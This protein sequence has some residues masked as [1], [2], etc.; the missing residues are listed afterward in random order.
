MSNTFPA[1]VTPVPAQNGIGAGP[2]A[3]PDTSGDVSC[4]AYFLQGAVVVTEDVVPSVLSVSIFAVKMPLDGQPVVPMYGY[5]FLPFLIVLAGIVTLKS[6]AVA[7]APG[8]G[9]IRSGGTSKVSL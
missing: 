7:Y 5:F 9:W 4:A 1:R 2:K 3:R 6:S 8:A